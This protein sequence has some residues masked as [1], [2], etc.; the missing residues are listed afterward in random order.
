MEKNN[1]VVTNIG[2]NSYVAVNDHFIVTYNVFK[3]H[4]EAVKTVKKMTKGVKN[5]D[6]NKKNNITYYIFANKYIYSEYVIDN[7]KFIYSSAPRKYMSEVIDSFKF[8]NY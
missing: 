3:N 7:N 1:F 8:L 5:I 4:K 2:V 6:I